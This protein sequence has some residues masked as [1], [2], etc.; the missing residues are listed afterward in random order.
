MAD[1]DPA[2]AQASARVLSALGLAA[3]TA[4]SASRAVELGAAGAFGLLVVDAALPPDGGLA[5]ARRLDPAGQAVTIVV[6]P[7]QATAAES[8]AAAAAAHG[9]LAKPFF[10]KDLQGLA[11]RLLAAP[12]HPRPAP[13]APPPSA[14]A[15]PLG[16]SL[17]GRSFGGCRVERLLG[18]GGMGAV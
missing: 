18:R 16:D 9:V 11:A 4:F 12:A 1:D 3:P 13:A 17:A 7:P 6:L 8:E 14:P 15:E 10:P 5:L 2:S